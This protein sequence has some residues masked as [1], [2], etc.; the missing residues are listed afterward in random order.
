[1][2]APLNQSQTTGPASQPA[3][4][5]GS[6]R[7]ESQ[8]AFCLARSFSDEEQLVIQCDRAGVHRADPNREKPLSR[9]VTSSCRPNTWRKTS[10][11]LSPRSMMAKGWGITT[12]SASPVEKCHV[13]GAG[14]SSTLRAIISSAPSE[15]AVAALS[16]L[17]SVRSSGQVTR[18]SSEAP[19]GGRDAGLR[20]HRHFEGPL[21]F[22]RGL[23][24]G[25]G[26]PNSL[27]ATRQQ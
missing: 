16:L 3:E 18:G 2:S 4:P 21:P 23:R 5:L 10:C 11:Q 8:S 15:A 20:A 13:V 14:Y 24:R 6:S 1:M 12:C 7:S 25:R 9:L 27:G 17:P 19:D 26:N 22:F